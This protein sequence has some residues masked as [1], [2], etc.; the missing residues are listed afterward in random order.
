MTDSESPSRSASKA[1]SHAAFSWV[2]LSAVWLVVLVA[3]A[4]VAEIATRVFVSSGDSPNP[5]YARTKAFIS[6][7]GLPKLADAI[8]PDDF[9]FWRL[10]PNLRDYRMVGSMGGMPIDF[11]M[12]TSEDGLR[13]HD[14]TAWPVPR[15]LY[16]IG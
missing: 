7:L 16:Q 11:S 4:G 15:K 14:T 9:L 10:A 5:S 2:K 12:T 8:V 1:T 13:V 3:I 6:I